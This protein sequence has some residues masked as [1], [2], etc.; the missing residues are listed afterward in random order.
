MRAGRLINLVLILQQQG[1][2]TAQVLAEQLEV[3]ERTIARD[4]EAL[5][6]AGVPIFAI[7][8]VHGGYQLVD[9]YQ[10]RLPSTHAADGGGLRKR[11]RRAVVRISPDGRRLAALLDRLQPLRVVTDAPA[12]V[13]GWVLV[14]FR[15][16]SVDAAAA[17]LL[18]LGPEVEVVEPADLRDTVADR[19][20][21]TADRYPRPHRS[22]KNPSATR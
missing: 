16:D 7:R 17:D 13:D 21:R 2:A 15:L 19:V 18:S 3:S 5:S 1:R 8:G 14:R 6:G 4:V 22:R 9:G 10:P 11:S 20:H 12:L